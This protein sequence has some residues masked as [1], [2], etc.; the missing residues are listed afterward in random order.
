MSPTSEN[1]KTLEKL[2]RL[3][4]QEAFHR[5]TI[6]E[7]LAFSTRLTRNTDLISLYRESNTLARKILNLDF[8]T[9]MILSDDGKSLIIRDAIGFPAS[10]INTFALVEGQGLSTYVVT[11]RKAAVVEDFTVEKRFAVP[12]VVFQQGITSALSVPM[13]L[14]DIVFGVMIGHTK[15]KRI[16]SSEEIDLYQS[17]ANQ[18]AVAIKNVMHF[19]SLQ[20]SQKRF[21]TLIDRAGD[22]IYVADMNGRLVDVN[23]MACRTLG[24]SREELLKLSVFDV[25]PMAEDRRPHENLWANLSADQ[26]V[27]INSRHRRKDGSLFPVEIRIGLL[28]LHEQN[29]LLGFARDV[30]KR[31]QAE[32]EKQELVKQLNQAQ[33]MESIGT[34]AGGIAHDFNNI[35]T[36]I[37]GYL[38]LA[39][40]KATD[41]PE[42]EGDLGEIW[43]AADRAKEMVK[44]I[45]AFSRRESEDVYP[46]KMHIVIK[47]VL[48]LLRS[49]IPRTIEIRHNI[50]PHCGSVLADPTHIH[51]ILMNLCT[52][53][54]HAMRET[55]GILDVALT[56]INVS[57]A[58]SIGSINLKPGAYLRLDV[59]D[60]GKGIVPEI[61]ERIFDPYFTTKGPGEG[62]G[63]GLSVVHG[64]VTGIG[65][66]ITLSS[67]PEKGTSFHIYLPVIRE[68]PA[69]EKESLDGPVPTG[70]ETIMIID[71]EEAVLNVEKAILTCL[72]YTVKAFT[73]P[74][75]ALRQFTDN[76]DMFD[77]V[78]TDMT[79]PK[80]TGDKL[81]QE[82]LALKPSIPVIICTGYSE[83]LDEKTAKIKG[84]KKF[85]TKPITIQSFGRTTRAVLDR[86]RAENEREK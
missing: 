4:A 70:N 74:L 33:K 22:A 44:Q 42:L 38:E 14:G 6:A 2:G 54:Y 17:I 8:S 26:Y 23:E 41:D 47:E 15:R 81:A 57:A 69:E 65:G 45:L 32:K 46:L 53:A 67:E 51:Q 84:I 35:L 7:I 59:S 77:L 19:Q 36:P 5:R 71:D 80:L 72:G 82:L 60:T 31:Q 76:P 86:V 75:Q 63:M 37:F 52:N 34:L 25:E 18:S 11:E 61:Q 1:Q 13:M 66:Q 62:T 73:S 68:C 64:I 12:P 29:Y 24:Y 43:K 58:S 83:L 28:P 39:M 40:L 21:R 3:E 10:M 50:D 9:L 30:S 85:V 48:N 56:Q 79:M 16:F 49:S 55:G 20:D 78:I 27:T